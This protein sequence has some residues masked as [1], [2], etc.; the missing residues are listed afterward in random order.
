MIDQEETEGIGMFPV[1]RLASTL[2][3]NY[4]VW[5]TSVL[6]YMHAGYWCGKMVSAILLHRQLLK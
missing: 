3:Q 6:V 2:V 5:L 1:L 4:C